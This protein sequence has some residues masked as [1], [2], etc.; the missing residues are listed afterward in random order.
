MT[1]GEIIITEIITG[2]IIEIGQETGGTI[3]GQV[4]EVAAIGL[5]IDEEMTG[6]IMDRVTKG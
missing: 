3:I 1:V 5:T 6:Q 2:Q 4:I